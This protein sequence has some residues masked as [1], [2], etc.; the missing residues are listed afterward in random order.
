MKVSNNQ[1]DSYKPGEVVALYCSNLQHVNSSRGIFIIAVWRRTL[2][3]PHGV[4]PCR[5]WRHVTIATARRQPLPAHCTCAVH[6]AV[7]FQWRHVSGAHKSQSWSDVSADRTRW[8][9]GWHHVVDTLCSTY[10]ERRIICWM[11]CTKARFPLPELT[12]RVNG[13]SWQVT[14]FHYPS[15]RRDRQTDRQN[16]RRGWSLVAIIVGR[17]TRRPIYGFIS[18]GMW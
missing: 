4:L 13:P 2:C 14:G 5:W 7:D 9:S 16:H 3:P 17:N 10:S 12:A 11:R 18:S 1:Y 8:I 6:D 15:T